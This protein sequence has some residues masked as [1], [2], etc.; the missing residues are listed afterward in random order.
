M[1]TD[2][3]NIE[4]YFNGELNAPGKTLFNKRITEDNEFAEAVAFYLSTQNELKM[5]VLAEKK[6]RFREIYDQSKNTV[7]HTG[8]I[9]SRNLVRRLW[10]YITAAAVII[11]V[12]FRFVFFSGGIT[13]LKLADEYIQ[14]NL[15][16][17]SPVLGIE[18]SMERG[19][20]LFNEKKYNEALMLFEEILVR[21]NSQPE[22]IKYAGIV[23][24]RMEQYDKA[25]G[26]FKQ[27]E[28]MKLEKNP[29]KFYQALT[30]MKR[31]QPGDKEK[32]LQ[33]LKEVAGKNLEGSNTAKD[34]LNKKWE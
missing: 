33:L 15:Q 6:Q 17:I 19:K 13:P 5:Q 29:G 3:E 8:A 7:D 30:L 4:A 24:L 2:L 23:S 22:A 34:W 11:A 32:E 31:N 12:V 27:L 26:Y 16:E 14:Q 20:N 25:I 18:D 1:S 9:M 10:P 21:D 28:N